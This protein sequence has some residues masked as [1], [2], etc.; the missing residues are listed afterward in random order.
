MSI[1]LLIIRRRKS[2]RQLAKCEISLGV[3]WRRI[4]YQELREATNDCS[5]TNIIGSFCSV[6]EGTLSDG[7]NVAV[8]VFN[9]QPDRVT[10]RFVKESKILSII[11]N[12]NLA[13]IIGCCS[14]TEFKALILEYMPNGS[15]EKWLYSHNY[16]LDMLKRLDMAIDV[17]LALEYLHHGL[18]FTVLHCDLKPSNVLLNQDMVGHVGDFGIAKLFSQGESFAPTKTLATIGYMSPGDVPYRDS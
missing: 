1:T 15:L 9:F 11:R 10:N 14:N 7:L 16:F 4:S 13:R 12:R 6:Y 2:D 8:K 17:A 18:K 3:E 5:E